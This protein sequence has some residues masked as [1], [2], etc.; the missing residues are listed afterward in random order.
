[1]KL[2]KSKIF[3][4]TLLIT[5]LFSYSI[6]D[7]CTSVLVTK[8]ASKKGASIISYSCDGEFHPILQLYLASDHKPG[9]MIEYTNW[10]GKKVSFPQVPHTYKV[11]G[12]MNEF[13]VAIG[14][15]TFDGRPELENTEGMFDYYTLMITAL[16]R[17]KT[18]RQAIEVI[19]SLANQFGYHSTGESFS[20]AD[21]EEAWV[22]ELIG[23]GAGNKGAVWVA[24]KLPDGTISAHANMSRIHEFPLNDPDNCIYSKDV[25]S[26]AV[27]KGFYK[28]ES[29]KPFSFSN[30]YNPPTEE[31][32]RYSARRVWSIFRRLAPSINLSPDYSSSVKGSVPYPL[33]IKPDR[34]LDVQDVIAMHR[35]H[36]EGTEFDMTKDFSSGAFGSADKWRPMKWEVDGKKYVWERPIATQQAAFVFVSES[37]A[38]VP[39]EIGGVYWLGLDNP[40]TN[41]F[42]PLYTSINELPKSYTVGSLEKFSRESAWWAFNFVANYANLR[43]SYMIKD[44][45]KVQS[46]IEGIQF[47]QQNA[48]ESAAAKFLKEDP[49]MVP[50]YL[51]KY[52]VD[53][54]EMTVQ[55]WWS[56]GDLLIAK[57]NDGYIQDEKGRAHEV[58]YP[59]DWLNTIPKEKLNKYRLRQERNGQGEL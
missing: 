24:V 15:T 23:K 44:I 52:C 50:K 26:F 39:D 16:Q 37:R 14:E 29:G 41:V 22:M 32:I 33:Y 1:M 4:L 55:K 19:T 38:S 7:A 9:T 43:Y 5:H 6:A 36:Y 58:G 51:T 34:K 31:Q 45:Q 57:Y 46:E 48:I 54:A 53:N 40:Y 13:Q 11:V 18:A 47:A 27:E 25:I 35:D 12:L 2:Y 59:Q 28:P 20:I 56:L 17:S 10:M 3:V 49:Q 8:G 42:V 21:K 30:A